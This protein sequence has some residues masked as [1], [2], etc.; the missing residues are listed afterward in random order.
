MINRKEIVVE[1]MINRKMINKEEIA[2]DQGI[3]RGEQGII[4]VERQGTQQMERQGTQQMAVLVIH[5]IPQIPQTEVLATQPRHQQETVPST[6]P[7]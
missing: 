1:K 2:V 4:Q 5:R 3:P 6:L 7:E